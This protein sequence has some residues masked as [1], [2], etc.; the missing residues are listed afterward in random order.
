MKDSEEQ[1]TGWTEDS[2]TATTKRQEIVEKIASIR[3]G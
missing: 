1:Q 3:W 2:S